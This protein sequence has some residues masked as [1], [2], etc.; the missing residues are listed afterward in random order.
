MKKIRRHF[1]KPV[2]QQIYDILRANPPTD[3]KAVR[4]KNSEMTAYA[5]GFTLPHEPFRLAPRGS[6]AYAAWAAGV[7]NAREKEKS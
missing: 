2:L 4:G 6:R 1:K 5:V 3:V 7:D